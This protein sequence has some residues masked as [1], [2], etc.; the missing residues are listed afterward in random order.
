MPPGKAG[1]EHWPPGDERLAEFQ[2]VLA[3]HLLSASVQFFGGTSP[4]LLPAAADGTGARRGG[5]RSAPSS[6]G[7]AETAGG[8]PRAVF[9][10]SAGGS[11][12]AGSVAGCVGGPPGACSIA[13]SAA[14]R[15]GLGFVCGYFC[16]FFLSSFRGA[17]E[18]SLMRPFTNSPCSVYPPPSM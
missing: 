5:A 9:A 6:P 12:D 10:E 13:F 7:G 3:L 14:D 4:E 8:G 2:W 1:R 11:G 17:N 15:F 18:P 16:V